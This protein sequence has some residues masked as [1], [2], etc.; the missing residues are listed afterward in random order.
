MNVLDEDHQVSPA[1][2]RHANITKSLNELI[3]ICRG[4]LADDKINA[5]ELVY[6]H[7]WLI[8]HEYLHRDGDYVDLL[9]LTTELIN[10]QDFDDLT[11]LVNEIECILEFRSDANTPFETADIAV[12]RLI[13]LSRGL[14]SDAEL[15]DTEIK[16]LS[17][18]LKRCHQFINVWPISVIAKLVESILD[19]GIITEEERNSLYE[20]LSSLVGGTMQ[21]QGTV[22]GNSGTL[23]LDDVSKVIFDG[24]EFCLTGQ[25]LYGTRVECNNATKSLGGKVTKIP[26]RST[27]YVVVGSL[28][29][30]DWKQ[31]S[32][33]RKIE[34][35]L[36]LKNKGQDILI[37]SE[38]V[39]R[40][41]L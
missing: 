35:A 33:G 36:D 1:I 26:T 29:S 10:S 18:W 9:E 2:N 30:R 38:S 24:A 39:W 19:D 22:T 13:G 3:G 31:S 21:E 5:D 23:A 12:S 32:H 27:K 4:I 7:T 16:Y 34:K 40:S 37:I 20:A 17:Q 11:D 6:L 41:N 15:S 28:S 25:F 14:L 8:E